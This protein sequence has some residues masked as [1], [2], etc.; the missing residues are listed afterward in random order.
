MVR[1]SDLDRALPRAMLGRAQQ[2]A[3]LMGDSPSPLALNEALLDAVSL[4][5][6]LGMRYALVGG[7]AAMYYGRARFTDD[8]DFVSDLMFEHTLRTHPDEMRNFNFDPTCAFK[9]YHKS[10]IAIALLF[11]EF[12]H[13]IPER[14]VDT[15]LAGRTVKVADVNDLV[16]MKLR[17]ARPQ[18][19]YDVSEM[20]KRG[21]I[22][23]TRVRALVNA[24]EFTHHESV[25]ARSGG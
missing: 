22:D 16:A 13:G 1:R 11:D 15:P 7:L 3:L 8:V 19:D 4:F 14:A 10:G 9:L 23:E 24:E 18:D 17:A 21:V 20:I 12:A 25:N 2:R 6:Y 5:E